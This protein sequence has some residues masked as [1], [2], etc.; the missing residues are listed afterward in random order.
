MDTSL[1]EQVMINQFVMAAGSTREQAR[2]LLQ[3]AHWQFETALSIFFQE[4]VP[5]G[6][7]PQQ[8]NHLK[9]TNNTLSRTLIFNLTLLLL[10]TDARTQRDDRCPKR[11]FSPPPVSP[12]GGGG[13]QMSGPHQQQLLQQQQSQQQQQQLQLQQHY[14]QQQQHSIPQQYNNNSNQMFAPPQQSQPRHIIANNVQIN[15]AQR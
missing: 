14:H 2:Q 8:F 10:N 15:A 7:P 6:G 4:S 1:R 11:G 13:L 3:M 9:V 5:N 12:F